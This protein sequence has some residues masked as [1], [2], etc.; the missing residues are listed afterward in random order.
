MVGGANVFHIS[1]ILLFLVLILYLSIGIVL[2]H[3]FSYLI[4]NNIYPRSQLEAE[5]QVTRR[6][7]V[8][9]QIWFNIKRDDENRE[10]RERK[11]SRRRSKNKEDAFFSSQQQKRKK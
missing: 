4:S 10:S 5:N 11:S 2:F 7:Q 9:A 3:H 6:E 1:Q 8:V